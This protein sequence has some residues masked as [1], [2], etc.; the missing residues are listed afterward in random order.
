M[1]SEEAAETALEAA[2]IKI[3]VAEDHVQAQWPQEKLQ[4]SGEQNQENDG[5][6]KKAEAKESR[7]KHI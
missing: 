6:G 5:N 4:L 2:A 7:W 1:A 3:S